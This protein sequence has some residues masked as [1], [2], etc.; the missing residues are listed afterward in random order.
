MKFAK[1]EALWYNDSRKDAWYNSAGSPTVLMQGRKP[2]R[3][4]D[5]GGF[6]LAQFFKTTMI[7]SNI[8]IKM[9]ISSMLSPP[10]KNGE[11]NRQPISTRHPRGHHSRQNRKM[12]NG[13]HDFCRFRLLNFQLNFP[14]IKGNFTKPLQKTCRIKEMFRSG[15]FCHEFL[16]AVRRRG[17]MV[18]SVWS[19]SMRNFLISW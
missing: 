10:L 19:I 3:L 4:R 14:K 12:Q 15:L 8:I 2:P 18:C 13:R 6:F 9:I 1:R 16:M 11:R 5:V 7:A 17:R